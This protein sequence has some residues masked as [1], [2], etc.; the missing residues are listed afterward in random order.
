MDLDGLA[1]WCYAAQQGPDAQQLRQCRDILAK[2]NLR[3][4]SSFTGGGVAAAVI[5]F[6]RLCNS[7]RMQGVQAADPPTD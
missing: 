5:A 3:F 7:D 4:A 2:C 1:C 6:Y